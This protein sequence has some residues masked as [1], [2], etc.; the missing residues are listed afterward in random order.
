MKFMMSELIQEF[1]EREQL[2]DLTI[3]DRYMLEWWIVLKGT[4]VPGQS[5]QAHV[6]RLHLIAEGA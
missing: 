5:T 6:A 3:I 2:I 1:F 4:C